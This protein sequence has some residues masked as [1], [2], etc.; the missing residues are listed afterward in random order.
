MNPALSVAVLLVLHGAGTRPPPTQVAVPRCPGAPIAFASSGL[1]A[2]ASKPA[3]ALWA[4]R[5]QAV[6]VASGP[7]DVQAVGGA[8]VALKVRSGATLD[9]PALVR[10]R[11]AI[12][13]ASGAPTET[14]ATEA[15]HLV[16][17][18]QPSWTRLVGDPGTKVEVRSLAA[19]EAPEFAL[20]A[21]GRLVG[22]ESGAFV[23]RYGP[24]GKPGFLSVLPTPE[25]ET[26]ALAHGSR[27]TAFAAGRF[28][29]SLRC[30]V[31]QGSRQL[32]S[33]KRDS[34]FLAHLDGQGAVRWIVTAV[35]ASV[36][37][38]ETSATVGVRVLGSFRDEAV[39]GTGPTALTLKASGESLYV[40]EY[41]AEGRLLSARALGLVG[42][43]AISSGWLLV[44][45]PARPGGVFEVPRRPGER[46]AKVTAPAGS[47]VLA[48]YGP[49]GSLLWSESVSDPEGALTVVDLSYQA[50]GAIELLATTPNEAARWFR[51][52]ELTLRRDPCPQGAVGLRDQATK[53][54]RAKKFAAACEGFRKAVAGCPSAPEY[55]A[56]LGLC[57]ARLGKTEEA[58]AANQRAILEATG[59]LPY[60][61]DPEVRSNA[62]FN[63]AKLGVDLAPLSAEQR[64]AR[65][66]PAPGCATPLFACLSM[67]GSGGSH[68]SSWTT[69][70]WFAL[71]EEEARYEDGSMEP[72]YRGGHVAGLKAKL[73]DQT[74]GTGL[75]PGDS[76]Y[77]GARTCTVVWA[78]ACHG[79]VG[80]WCTAEGWD[81]PPENGAEEAG[82]SWPSASPVR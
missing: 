10:A 56:D 68:Q 31:P 76:Q 27:G 17:A 32:L 45:S 55:H 28:R 47:L 44:A 20:L 49:E 62:Y 24:G 33:P 48:E 67:W 58:L 65:V 73:E 36:T 75:T 2:R 41:D 35:G 78:D 39:F 42:R 14:P 18:T 71:T 38:L 64:C 77:S 60:Q 53:D 29:E 3:P 46:P 26:T 74:Y 34:M 80:A 81:R 15:A 72:P 66:P 57:L 51:Y 69:M 7:V 11:G 1:L 8:C 19:V 21:G 12:P 16:C 52:P 54:F 6:Q 23:A 63:L 79:M 25:G 4:C 30:K 59:P 70:L 82:A 5:D 50:R 43:A 13:A 9:V 22:P 40:A 37:A 61:G